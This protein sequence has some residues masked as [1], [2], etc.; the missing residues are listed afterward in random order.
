MRITDLIFF[1]SIIL[2][3]VLVIFFPNY[4][5]GYIWLYFIAPIAFIKVFFPKSKITGWLEKERFKK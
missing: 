5:S 3:L 4:V 1:G 2:S